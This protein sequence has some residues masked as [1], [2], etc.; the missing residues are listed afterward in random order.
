M[1]TN[2]LPTHGDVRLVSDGTGP[3]T[4]V[5]VLTPEGW[6]ELRGVTAIEWRIDGANQ[7]AALVVTVLP[8]ETEIHTDAERVAL[9]QM[10]ELPE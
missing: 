6:L 2:R 8:L 5:T 4:K 9:R 1:T 7:L 10:K 3:Q